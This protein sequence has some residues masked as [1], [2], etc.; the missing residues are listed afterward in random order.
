MSPPLVGE[1]HPP[2]ASPYDVFTIA[3]VVP[4]EKAA[5]TVEEMGCKMVHPA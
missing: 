3:E 5:G 1:V 2:K 4:G